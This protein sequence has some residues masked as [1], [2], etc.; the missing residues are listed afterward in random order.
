[1]LSDEAAG[2]SFV[3]H[4]QQMLKKI[5]LLRKYNLFGG[6]N[7]IKLQKKHLFFCCKN[8][9][10]K[11]R[12]IENNLIVKIFPSSLRKYELSF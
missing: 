11:I 7:Q 5:V 4:C 9:S 2:G 12:E 10:S 8:W 3:I 1:M 6:N